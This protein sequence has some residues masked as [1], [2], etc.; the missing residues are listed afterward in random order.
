MKFFASLLAKTSLALILSVNLSAQSPELRQF[1][2]SVDK[3]PSDQAID[4]ALKSSSLT[5]EDSPFHAVLQISQPGDAGS[6]YAGTIEVYWAGPSRYRVNVVSKTFNQTRIVNGTDV[7]ERN[8][9]DFYPAWLRNYELAILDPLPMAH[10]FVGR[11]APV[12]LGQNI[13]QSCVNRDDRTNGITDQ[14]T[15]AQICFQGQEP[16]IKYAMDFTYFMEFGDYKSFGK[17]L[18]ARS[19]TTYTDGN[20][21]VIGQLKELEPLNSNDDNLFQVSNPT[22]V[23]QQIQTVFVSMA[24]NQSLLENVPTIDWPPVHE[25]KTEGNMIVHVITDR[26]GQVR[27]AYKHNSDNAGTEAF[28]TQQALKYKFKPLMVNGVAVQMETPLVLHF[29][30]KIGDPIPVLTGGDIK[31]YAPGCGYNPVLPKGLLPSGTTF[32]I[33]VSVNERGEDT[34]ET[35]PQDIPW[36]VV[37]RAHIDPRSCHFKPYLINGQPW[38]HHI[39]FVFTA[40]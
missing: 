17:K 35:F 5:T 1:I 38:Y 31:K 15:W 19:Y 10:D 14:T 13:S 33:R 24:A 20:E 22:P 21:K 28:G 12:M 37:Q 27:E 3:I 4:R 36:S 16:R 9:G 34:G 30:T 18:V 11:N 26:T 40:P 7:E 39:D 2:E 23:T 29:S 6:P 25:G 32:K 8:M